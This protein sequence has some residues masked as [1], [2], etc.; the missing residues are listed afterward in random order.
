MGP[1]SLFIW[2]FREVLGSVWDYLFGGSDI[3]TLY[4]RRG[5]RYG[6]LLNTLET[7]TLKERFLRDLVHPQKMVKPD[8]HGVKREFGSDQQV[9]ALIERIGAC[10]AS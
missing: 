5:P 2:R 1:H 10:R 6:L 4:P 7:N 8:A 3:D 9:R